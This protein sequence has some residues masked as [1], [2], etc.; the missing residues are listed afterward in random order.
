MQLARTIKYVF[1]DKNDALW[2]A[3]SDGTLKEDKLQFLIRAGAD[4]NY[5]PPPDQPSQSSQSNNIQPQYTLLCQAIFNNHSEIIKLLLQNGADPNISCSTGNSPLICAILKQNV[6]AVEALIK[7]GANINFV[8]DTLQFHSDTPLIY[9]INSA[10]DGK[11]PNPNKMEII[12]LLLD[13]PNID[14]N[15]MGF[16]EATPLIR[17]SQMNNLW[18]DPPFGTQIQLVNTLLERGADVNHVDRMGY[19]PLLCALSVSSRR[20]PYKEE[21][22]KLLIEKGANINESRRSR[23]PLWVAVGTATAD[24]KPISI[25]NYMNPEI[26]FVEFLLEKG[27]NPFLAKDGFTPYILS[28]DFKEVKEVIDKYVERIKTRLEKFLLNYGTLNCPAITKGEMDNIKEMIR[29]HKP[30]REYYTEKR[31]ASKIACIMKMLFYN[32][33]VYL[34]EDENY[35]LIQRFMAENESG[36]LFD[37]DESGF[38][39]NPQAARKEEKILDINI[40]A[41]YGIESSI[42]KGD[43]GKCQCKKFEAFQPGSGPAGGIQE[44]CKNCNHLKSEHYPYESGGRRRTLKKRKTKRKRRTSKRRRT[45][46]RRNN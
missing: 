5:V 1:K 31:D 45:L 9:A 32:K 11:G 3:V 24:P 34:G 6:T 23:S 28:T 16:N 43:E 41:E 22:V 36:E 30:L 37:K 21:L 46:K 40:N 14:V 29:N 39:S 20:N 42:C 35:D 7:H 10:N 13:N 4:I 8:D 26:K 12:Q 19:S 44:T 17:A 2:K 18:M 15:I 38:A 25:N 27:A 33:Q